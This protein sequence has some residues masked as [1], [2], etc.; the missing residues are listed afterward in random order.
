MLSGLSPPSLAPPQPPNWN[1]GVGNLP[2]VVAWQQTLAELNPPQAHINAFYKPINDENP[3]N[4]PPFNWGYKVF[5]WQMM[6][7]PLVL[8]GLSLAFRQMDSNKNA[9]ELI[10]RQSGENS[11]EV[12]G[13]YMPKRLY[14]RLKTGERYL[15]LAAVGFA[16]ADGLY[17]GGKAFLRSYQQTKNPTYATVQGLSGGV[18]EFLL[19]AICGA[20]APAVMVGTLVHQPLFKLYQKALALLEQHAPQQE[21]LAK[22]ALNATAAAAISLASV[23]FVPVLEQYITPAVQQFV[24]DVVFRYSNRLLKASFPRTYEQQKKRL[25]LEETQHHQAK[26]PL[27][28]TRP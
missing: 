21:A 27:Q 22:P 25:A 19:Q 20:L 24:N 11:H 6:F 16:L 9:K 10:K 23:L 18:G 8:G 15:G 12:F 14:Q 28:G 5:E 2:F 3:L 4:K 1:V 7:M 26:A 13:Y 17:F